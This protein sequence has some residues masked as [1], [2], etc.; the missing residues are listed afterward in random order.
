MPIFG[1]IRDSDSGDIWILPEAKARPR[2]RGRRGQ[3][4]RR[5]ARRK[6][7]RKK[8]TPTFLPSAKSFL[9]RVF[10]A[11]SLAKTSSRVF[12]ARGIV[13]CSSIFYFLFLHEKKTLISRFF[14]LG[15]FFEFLWRT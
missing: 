12:P 6:R 5:R 8:N 11:R 7:T 1:E 4:Q 10:S 3:A 15:R 2:R 13:S 14:R 9:S